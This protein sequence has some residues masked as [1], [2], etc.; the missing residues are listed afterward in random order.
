VDAAVA[1]RPGGAGVVAGWAFTG[2]GAAAAATTSHPVTMTLKPSD[3]ADA[4]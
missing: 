3:R 2:G 4:V 1:A